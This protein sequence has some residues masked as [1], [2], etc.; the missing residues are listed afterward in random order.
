MQYIHVVQLIISLF[1]EC[2]CCLWVG[3]KPGVG[4]GV[5]LK[6]KMMY[7]CLP[8]NKSRGIRCKIFF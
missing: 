4:E 6:M 8:E 7:M 3:V 1:V 5:H 2:M